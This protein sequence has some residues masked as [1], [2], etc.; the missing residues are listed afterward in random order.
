MTLRGQIIPTPNTESELRKKQ[1]SGI[2]INFDKRLGDMEMVRKAYGPE[3][4]KAAFEKAYADVFGL[5][6]VVTSTK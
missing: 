6:H 5:E 4:D 1:W 3:K 2:R